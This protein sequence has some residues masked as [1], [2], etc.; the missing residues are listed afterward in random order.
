MQGSKERT[1][2]PLSTYRKNISLKEKS[3]LIRA[4][5][6]L[7]LFHL[8]IFYGACYAAQNQLAE[9]RYKAAKLGYDRLASNASLR[10]HR[11]NWTKVIDGFRKVYLSFPYDKDVAPKALFMMGRC[12]N[13]LYGYSRR[14]SD[15]QEALERYQV[16]LERFPD[17]R[18][19][20]DALYEIGQIYKRT[21][22][23]SSAIQAWKQLLEKYP[24]GSHAALARQRLAAMGIKAPITGTKQH[25][26]EKN[27]NKK[28]HKKH[29]D[30]A[31]D[32]NPAIIRDI[33]Y[34]SD[35]DYTRVVIHSSR[36]VSIKKG[37]LPANKKLHLPKRFYLDLSPAYKKISLR[38]YIKINNSLLKSVRIAQYAPKTVRVVFDLE[39]TE[40]TKV[41]YLRDP[42]RI[43]ADAF[44][45]HYSKKKATCQPPKSAKTQGNTRARS[46]SSSKKKLSLA[47]QLGLCVRTIVI[48]PGHGGKDPGARGPTGLKEKNVV[49]K[50]AKRVAKKLKRDLDCRVILTRRSDRYL[51]L[52]QRTAIANA[53]KADL[54]VSIHANAAPTRRLRGVETY[55]LNFALDADAMR[56][57]AR[58]NATSEKRISELKSI[59]NDIMKN[60]KVNESSRLATKIQTNL[61]ATL[62]R[63]YK[64]IRN[65]GVKQAPFFVLIGAR[66]P[67]A[68][69]EVSFISNREEERRLKSPAY[70]DKVAAGIATGI[71]KY[72][73]ETR[74]AYAR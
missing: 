70:L 57:A 3:R 73:I 53:R 37:V 61:V 54:F 74:M 35:E 30:M 44:G 72:I 18:L 9:R 63:R 66:M 40:K 31:T 13:E 38:D 6:A 41:F 59:L 14:H 1:L 33:K 47:Q 22:R 17:S 56:V 34:W 11:K 67:S 24:H 15:I 7:F 49:L 16:L 26:Q 60:S 48:D 42:F 64:H 4:L 52:T 36:P 29:A 23:P 68:L 32:R 43:V 25:A 21:G 8:I 10:K 65:L 39:K 71:E 45:S 28:A 69:V 19:A 62:K 58:E 51:P 27:N 46:G 55:F 5:S 50:I 12:Y 20:D 2:K